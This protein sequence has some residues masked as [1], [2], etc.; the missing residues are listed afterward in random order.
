MLF[1]EFEKQVTKVTKLELP[2]TASHEA[3]APAQRIQEL[4][5]VFPH[6][7]NPKKAAVLCLFY[8][9]MEQQTQFVLILRKTYKGVHSAQVGFPGGKVEKSDRDL[10]HT[11]LRETEEEVGVPQESVQ[12]LKSLTE[13]YIPPSNFF[14]HPFMG[15]TPNTPT[16]VPQP[17]EV[18]AILEVPLAQFLDDRVF[19]TRELS[20]SYAKQIQVPAFDLLGHV[21]WGATAMML[22][23]VHQLLK[24]IL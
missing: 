11:A 24:K 23:E 1:S 8:P 18:E 2:G 14:V 10:M 20:T 3:M 7:V 9:S 4:K 16:L 19:I 15:I 22:S 13:V 12:I 5:K 6:K 17:E 21:V